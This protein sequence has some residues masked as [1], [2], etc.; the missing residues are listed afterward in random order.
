MRHFL[1]FLT[2]AVL[3]NLAQA[4][5]TSNIEYGRA[6]GVHLLLDACTPEGPGPF[7][8]VILVHG[9]GWID[10]DKT[11]QCRPLFEPLT[12]A[13]LA[14]FSVNYRLA[15]KYRYPAC[16]EDVDTSVRWIKAHAAEFNVDPKRLALLGESAGGHIVE[17]VT[18][19]A[20][21][22]TRMAAVVAFYAPC[23][24]VADTRRRGG[25]S[26]SM[27]ALFGL[28]KFDAAAE[29]VLRNASPINFLTTGDLPPFLLVHGTADTSVPY[30]QSLQWQ[31]RLRVL[32]VPCDLIT[33]EGAPHSM[34]RWEKIDTSYK[35]KTVVWLKRV[36]A[37]PKESKTIAGAKGK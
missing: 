6:D 35:D 25:L 26:R 19:R 3:P 32:S 17:M 21:P 22:G 9:G 33:V 20:T 4:G 15:P 13:G 16:I 12:A 37:A 7:A 2:A 30:V 10:G 34:L 29:D 14:W 8:G 36:L 18:V 31:A 1:A 5:L 27:K 23:D 24:L 28:T 11:V